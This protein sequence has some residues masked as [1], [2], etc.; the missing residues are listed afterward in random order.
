MQTILTYASYVL[1]EIND[2]D[3]ALLSQ[4]T[5]ICAIYTNTPT[6][7]FKM[8]IAVNSATSPL[9]PH[10]L[11]LLHFQPLLHYSL[12]SPMAVPGTTAWCWVLG[13]P[14]IC[15]LTFCSLDRSECESIACEGPKE[16]GHSAGLCIIHESPL[17]SGQL[18]SIQ[19]PDVVQSVLHSL[20]WL[21]AIDHKQGT[22]VLNKRGGFML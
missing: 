15:A 7:Q 10:N 8:R 1:F 19:I 17:L 11:Y 21:L 18:F 20:S 2:N 13:V 3:D 12:H 16:T 6:N 22:R 5:L 4:H 14:R 9:R